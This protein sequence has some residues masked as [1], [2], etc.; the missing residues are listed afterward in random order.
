MKKSC[1]QLAILFIVLIFIVIGYSCVN[2]SNQSAP[3]TVMIADTSIEQGKYLVQILGCND[4]HA[5]KILVNG[6]PTIDQDKLLAGYIANT[7]LPKFD[8]KLVKEGILQFNLDGTA[9]FGPWGTSFGA[10]LTPDETGIGNW[11]YE[12]FKKAL[13][14]GKNKGL[15]SGRTLLPPM[16]WPNFSIM[17]DHDIKAIFNYLKSIKPVD[18][19]VPPPIPL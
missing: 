1:K 9:A 16:P 17:K 14:Q 11:S 5:P 7:P 6:I 4:C 2:S 13:T 12:Q 19:V 18:N 8:K 3:S 10:N 15:E